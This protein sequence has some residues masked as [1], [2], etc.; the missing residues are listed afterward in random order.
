MPTTPISGSR[1]A[2]SGGAGAGTKFLIVGGGSAG[3]VLAAR[4]SEGGRRVVPRR[5]GARLRALRRRALARGHPRRPPARVLPR[6]GDRARGP[7]A[8]A[9]AD[10]RRLLGPQRLHRDPGRA[11]RLR[12]VGPRLE[13]RGDRAVPRRAERALRVRRFATEELSPGTARSPQAAG[14]DAIVHPSTPSGPCAGTPP[15]PTSTRRRARNLTIL[16]DALVDRVLLAGDRAIGVATT[17]ARCAPSRSCSPPAPTGRRGS[18][19]AA[20]S[21]P[22]AGCRW[23]R[24][25]GPR[26]RRVRVGARPRWS[27]RRRPSRPHGRF[28]GAGHARRRSSACPP[29]VW[30]VFLFPALDPVPGGLRAQRRRLRDEASSR[31]RSACPRPIR[32]AAGR[33]TTASSPTSATSRCWSRGGG[34]AAAGGDRRRSRLRVARDAPGP[35]VDAGTHVRETARGF[36]HP[37]APARRA[38]S[39]TATAGSTASTGCPSPTPRSCRRSRAP[40]PTS[41]RSRWPS[42]W[43]SGCWG[44]S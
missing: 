31:G 6:V 44:V 33:S 1:S 40:T 26:R 18:C 14:A 10:H 11:G 35:D 8:A 17:A 27:A 43:P 2:A 21:V 24:G 16:A 28:H 32:G 38:P 30:D 42:A 41:A 7:L 37:V 34:A 23:A 13:P 3:C 5:G 4:L 25:C 29:G 22:T 20:G 15:S 9:G 19:C 36:F 12:R 39:S